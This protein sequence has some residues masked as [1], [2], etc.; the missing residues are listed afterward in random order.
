[1]PPPTATVF[2]PYHALDDL[3]QRGP[4]SAQPAAS[5][6]TPGTLYSVTDEANRLERSDGTA[7]ALYAPT[8]SGGGTTT[9]DPHHATH[10]PGG[11]DALV[12]AAWTS[13]SNTFEDDQ[14]I[15]GDLV[16]T[17]TITPLTAAQRANINALI[18]DPTGARMLMSSHYVSGLSL[19]H[20]DTLEIGRVTCGNYDAQTYEPLVCEVESFQV[21]SG[22]SPA[23][24]E[25][26]VRVHPSGGV[27]VGAPPDHDLD[28]GVGIVRARGFDGTPLDA[29]QV[30]SGTLPDARL[31]ANVA[32]RDQANTFTGAP[33]AIVHASPGLLQ[34]HPSAAPGSQT[35]QLTTDG[36]TYQMQTVN[37]PGTAWVSTPFALS[38]LGDATIARDLYEKGR[39][40]PIG[41]WIDV[42]Y[43]AANFT[44]SGSMTWTVSADNV[45]VNRY[46]LIGHTL[47]WT[48]FLSGSS[49]SGT[50]GVSLSLVVPG[51]GTVS[52]NRG[53]WPT[54]Q[55]F[56]GAYRRGL[57]LAS[58]PNRVAIQI[59]GSLL[60]TLNSGSTV[61]LFTIM[62]EIT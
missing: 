33:Q 15:D 18:G 59:E 57:I 62:M 1:M 24:R 4:R 43:S 51:G 60:Y 34:R 20:D 11:G 17:G 14:T 32:R 5:A 28:P 8:G 16:V 44:G 37:D 61:L 56:D 30:T 21:H 9:P 25:E 53:S 47:L 23:A 26:H 46:T 41:H 54:S 31:S 3:L 50:A 36:T 39:P 52:N 45:S 27:T 2:V 49:L 40:S 58:A 55:L 35:W 22:V 13:Q 38:R 7:W 10:E 48:L 12:A 19:R 29:G 6:V 42:P